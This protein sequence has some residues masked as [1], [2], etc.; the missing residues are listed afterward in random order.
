MAGH[1]LG[2]LLDVADVAVA[3]AAQFGR[4]AHEVAVR[5]AADADGEQP[6]LAELS[7]DRSEQLMLVAD[8]AVGQEHDL[9]QALVVGR[10]AQ[11]QLEGR[12]HLGAA[13]G[14]ELLHIGPG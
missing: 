10:L 11:G 13:L 9:T 14:G 2:D 4:L 6:G 5:R 12:S 3:A 1:A 8:R 7:G